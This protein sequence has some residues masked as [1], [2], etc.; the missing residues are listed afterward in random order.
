MP[1]YDLYSA[2]AAK[3]E[4]RFQLYGCL[5]T[6][7]TL[8]IF[9]KLIS[10]LTPAQLRSYQ[11][12]LAQ[13][14]PAL[15]MSMRG[16]R[17]DTRRRER[18]EHEMRVEVAKLERQLARDPLV[19]ANWHETALNTGA[20]PKNKPRKGGKPGLHKWPRPKKGEAPIPDSAKVCELCGT[21]RLRPAPFD[22]NSPVQT[23]KLFYHYLKVPVQTGKTG[24][25]T[26]DDEALSKIKELGIQTVQDAR[27]KWR[28]AAL[29]GLAELCDMLQSHRDAQ[30]QLGFLSSRLTRD[31]RFASSFNVSAPWTGRWS[32]SK[33]PYGEGGNL[34][35]IGE[36]HRHIFLADPGNLL[37]YA[38]LKTA[39]SLHV[40]YLSG[41]ENYITAHEGDVHTWVTREL[42]PD[43]PWT[44]D[45]KKDKKIAASTNPEWD[46]A[47]GHDLRFQS[48]RIQHGSNYGLSPIGISL[49]ARIP[50]KAA[51]EAQDRYFKSFPMI[52]EYQNYIKGRV[53]Q[54]LT[55]YNAFG[56]P[57]NLMGRP[58]DGH[59]YKQG[60][61]FPAQSGIGD[62]LNLGLWR[63]WHSHDPHLLLCLAQIHD[64]VMGQ[65]P[66]ARLEEAKAAIVAALT[67]PTPVTDFRGRTRTCT[68][69]A[70]LAI[71]RNWGKRNPETNPDGIEEV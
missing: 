4:D 33:N 41:D 5:D 59:T 11:W 57:V 70:E 18:A 37:F 47:P 39:E 13:Q 63:L 52:K 69:K 50:R 9:N 10:R 42:W 35:N 34:Q 62:A 7:G 8:E 23:A 20:C 14:G 30:K 51:E 71:G 15:A 54:Q 6:T 21:S 61:A 43:L 65:F 44:G 24:G 49:I 22:P 1:I 28:K 48:K 56:S 31:G 45:I 64:A 25:P 66:E 3:G 26:T 53:E 19:V 32:S 17:V 29:P 2:Q 46:K 68:I 16:V 38:D 55:L 40:A 36:R 67:V 60:L 12:K 27:G 58:W